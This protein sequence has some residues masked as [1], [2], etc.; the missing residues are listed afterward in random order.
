MN[1]AEVLRTAEILAM[2]HL[3]TTSGLTETNSGPLP[4]CLLK[5][6]GLVRMSSETLATTPLQKRVD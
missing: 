4:P 3:G 2:T 5:T 1:L 6:G